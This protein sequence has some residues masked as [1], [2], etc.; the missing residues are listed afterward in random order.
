MPAH[1]SE[2]IKVTRDALRA[3]NGF[4]GRNFE[5]CFIGVSFSAKCPFRFLRVK[6]SACVDD[7]AMSDGVLIRHAQRNMSS[8]SIAEGDN[9]CE[10]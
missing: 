8:T 4:V 2:V 7:L 10:L 9:D 6:L 3:C 1:A 5:C